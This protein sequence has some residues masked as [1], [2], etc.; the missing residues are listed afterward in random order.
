MQL[1]LLLIHHPRAM[2]KKQSFVSPFFLQGSICKRISLPLTNN[3]GKRGT[4]KFIQ[5]M[6]DNPKWGVTAIQRSLRREKMME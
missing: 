2:F 5:R 4:S 3:E 6:R 1:S